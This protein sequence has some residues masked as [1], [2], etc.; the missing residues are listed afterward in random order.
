VRASLPLVALAAALILE[1]A[2]GCSITRPTKPPIHRYQLGPASAAALA[3]DRLAV[4]LG[5]VTGGTPFRDTGIAYQV[6]PYRLDSYTFSRWA[7]PPVEI[8][9]QRLRH[10]V[11]PPP[12]ETL[13]SHDARILDVRIMAFQEVDIGG[14]IS[15]LVEMDFCLRP[16]R[17]PSRPQWCQTFRRQT[18]ASA[19]SREAAVAAITT[20][21]NGVIEELTVALDRQLQAPTAQTEYDNNESPMVRRRL[22]VPDRR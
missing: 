15:G 22:R 17:P 3:P 4:Q 21:F 11:E 1:G 10:L 14:R 18:P 7:G 13:G 19:D 16:I 6:S 5:A 20:S 8:V 2:G 9:T 12:A